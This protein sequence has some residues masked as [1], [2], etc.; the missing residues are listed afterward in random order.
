[1]CKFHIFFNYARTGVLH[2]CNLAVHGVVKKKIFSNLSHS[3]FSYSLF[4]Y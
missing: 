3:V 1:M 2:I 4:F